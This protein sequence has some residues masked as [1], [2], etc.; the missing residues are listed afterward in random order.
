VTRFRKRRKTVVVSFA[1]HEADILSNLLRNLVE[2]LYDGMPPRVTA[3]GDD[4]LAAL[5][6][7][8]GPTAPP[9]DVVLQRLLPNAY[10]GDDMAAAEFRR[11]T[12]RGLR[13]GKANDAKRVLTAL[14]DESAEDGIALEPDDQLAWLRALNDLRLA[15]GTRL[16]IKEDDDYAVWEKLPDDDPRRLT[17]DLYDWLGYL[18]SALLHNMR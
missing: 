15:I 10:S 12:E 1:E 4:P 8:D 14:E 13:D 11:F 3:A 7:S 17:Y 5:L 6:D 18:Q 2:L 16:D 9:E